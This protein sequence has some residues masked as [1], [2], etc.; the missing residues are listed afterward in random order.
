MPRDSGVRLDPD[1]VLMAYTLGY[2]PMA[3]GRR[4]ECVVW[5][6]PQ[7]RGVLELSQARASR[8]LRKFLRTE[9]FE[10]SIDQDFAGVIA[11][12]AEATQKRDD[13]WINPAI[14]DVYLELHRLGRA[15][16]V[17]CREN[18]RL[19][20]GLYGVTIGGVFCGESMFSRA[21]NASKIA[22]LHLIARL[23]R[24]GF[25][26]IDTQFWTPHLAQ[27]GVCETPN[28]AYQAR[29]AALIGARA[30]FRAGPSYLDTMTV[31]QSITQTS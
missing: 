22:M 11:G 16:S 27:F 4:D 29:L 25:S 14:E 18:G 5:V 20:G 15:H 9:P 19:V 31:L 21:T 30:D 24:N 2:F 28:D 8:S 7:L 10:V 23:K 6:L 1:E 3:R 26:L 17:E 12:C 13:T